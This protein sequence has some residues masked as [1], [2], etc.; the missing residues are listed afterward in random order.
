M[1]RQQFALRVEQLLRDKTL[2]REMGSKGAEIV[3]Q[4]FDFT[5]YVDGLEAMFAR[6]IAEART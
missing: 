2:A 1:D 4:K 5:K 6:T 3:R